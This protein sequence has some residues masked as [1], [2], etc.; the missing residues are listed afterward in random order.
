M[1]PGELKR[2]SFAEITKRVGNSGDSPSRKGSRIGTLHDEGGLTR[3]LT[4]IRL[5]NIFVGECDV[6]TD[7]GGSTGVGQRGGG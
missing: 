4:V 5:Y 6:R 3:G 2:S 1:L 7:G